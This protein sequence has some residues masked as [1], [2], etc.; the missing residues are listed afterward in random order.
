MGLRIRDWINRFPCWSMAPPERTLLRIVA[1]PGAENKIEFSVSELRPAAVRLVEEQNLPDTSRVILLLLPHSAELFLLHLGLT[2]TGRIPA[3]LP[4]PTLR[5]DR[6]KYQR[7]LIHQ[8]SNLP[9]DHLITLPRVAQNLAPALAYPVSRC[10]I[11]ASDHF[12]KGFSAQFDAPPAAPRQGPPA[13]RLS[14][15]VLFLQFSGGTTGAQKC[16]AVTESMMSAQ[17]QRL[18]HALRSDPR[19]G[20]VS[21]LPLY[22]DMG[23]VAC[24]WFPLWAGTPSTHFAASDWLLRPELLFQLQAEHCGTLCWLPNFAFS[25]LAARRELFHGRYRLDHVRAWIS[26]SEPV[27]HRSMHEFCSA[28]ADWG[29]RPESMQAS[30]AMAETVFAVTHTPLNRRPATLPKVGVIGASSGTDV[31]AF[32]IIDDVYV[33]SGQPL[34]DVRVEVIAP[35]GAIRPERAAGEICIS[36]PSLFRG[37]WGWRG[38]LSA[39]FRQD[40]WY[41][42]GDYGFLADGE[43]YVIG[44]LKDIIIVGGQNIFPED[45]EAI[46]NCAPGIYP[47]R[48]VAFGV[49]EIELGTQSMAVIAE[50]QGDFDVAA[51]RG[52]ERDIREL[53][54]AAL[55]VA[56][57]YVSVVPERWIVKSTA[58]KI[59]RSDTRARF[60]SEI[61]S[62]TVS[63]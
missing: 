2:M 23:L 40:G 16:V 37:Y 35:D 18:G 49:D 59:S 60:I 58:G 3:V 7:N 6:E 52:I 10:S 34:P 5:V 43:L 53:I 36:S 57:R 62:K 11:A 31:P 24:L 9:A 48:V 26:C 32:E 20:V 27:R 39:G 22:H 41:C 17:L 50:M 54:S 25:Y 63:T 15:D 47:G 21:W 45:A 61:L 29:V 1:A 12:E 38:F 51:A 30:Y 28:Y 14:E 46:A 8:L 13:E 56:P 42:T 44:R 55:T 33:S 19:D 4:W